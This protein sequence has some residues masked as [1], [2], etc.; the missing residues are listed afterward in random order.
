MY[1]YVCVCECMC[2][3]VS[4]GGRMRPHNQDSKNTVEREQTANRTQIFNNGN[5]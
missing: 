4:I 3:L 1:A 2:S 5:I